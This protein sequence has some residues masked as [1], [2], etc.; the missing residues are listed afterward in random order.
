MTS[1]GNRDGTKPAV[2]G[3]TRFF[4]GFRPVEGADGG[5]VGFAKTPGPLREVAAEARAKPEEPYV[6]IVDEINRANLAKVFCEL[7]FLLEYRH[8]AIRL[9]Y[10]RPRRSGCRPTCSSSAP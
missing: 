10:S 4:E 3:S 6:L 9:Q 5:A 1:T 8:D 7:Y 2:A